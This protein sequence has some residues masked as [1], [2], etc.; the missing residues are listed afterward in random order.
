MEFS[1]LIEVRQ[2]CRKFSAE[3]VEN[4]DILAC[5]EAFMLSPSACNAQPYHISVCTGEKAAAV[6]ECVNSMGMNPFAKNVPCFFVIREDSYSAAAALGGLIK[7]QDYRS[8]DIG[9]AAA[10]LVLCAADRGLNTCILGWFDEKKLKK[11]LGTSDRIRLVIALGR[12]AEGYPIRPKV[13]K[14]IKQISDFDNGK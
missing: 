12:A 7:G 5:L 4:E 1:K 3:K 2:S 6:S 8:I 9:I 13:R 11:L 14:S 10:H